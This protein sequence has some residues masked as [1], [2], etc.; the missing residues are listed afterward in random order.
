L[1]SGANYI[2]STEYG[3]LNKSPSVAGPQLQTPAYTTLDSALSLPT[4]GVTRFLVGNQVLVRSSTATRKVSYVGNSVQYD[5]IADDGQTIVESVQ[6][7]N[8]SSVQLTGVMEN[9]PEEFQAIYPINNWIT[10]NN[11]SATAK[12]QSGAAYIKRQSALV[13][14]VY[15]A[16]DCTNSYP[17]TSTRTAATTP[18]QT[19]A[20]LDNFFPISLVDPHTYESDFATDGT[21]SIINGVR[22]WVANQPM[23]P[24]DDTKAYRIY[25]E[26]NGNVYMGL[27]EKAG[28]PFLNAQTDGSVVNYSLAMNQAAVN[29]IQ[30]GVITGA[31]YGSQRGGTAE[32]PT[33]DLF[34]IG[35]HAVNGALTPVDLQAHYAIPATLTGAGQTIAIVDGPGSGSV[36]DDLNTFS[37]YYNLPL[38]DSSNPCF[39]RIDLSNGASFSAADDWGSELELDTQMVH[40]IAPGAKIILVTAN[41]GSLSDIFAAINYAAALPG[42]TA[43]TM[44]FS[45]GSY[46]PTDFLNE[47]VAL[48]GFQT[49][50]GVA[51]FASSGDNGNT[52]SFMDYPAASPYVTA[53]GGTRINSVAWSAGAQSEVAWPFSGGGESSYASMPAWQLSYLG[54]AVQAANGGMRAMPDVAAV[55][56][57]QHSAVAIYYKQRWVMSGGTSVSSP[58]WA[59][60]SALMGQKLANEGK[61]LASLIKTTPGGFNGLIYQSKV[62]QGPNVGFYDILSGSDN[63]YASPCPLCVAG[64]GYDEVT[65][66][67]APNVG[68]LLSNF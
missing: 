67:G 47:D 39:Q 11:F 1:V 22:M 24:V 4:L 55:A 54:S 53:V 6:Y 63:L 42:V 28:T 37:K 33:V 58:I 16:Q 14:D 19:E 10:A 31:A 29:S 27:L 61:S 32:V 34:G 18:C 46:F 41:S 50:Q 66:W 15:F 26:L 45:Y 8:F 64:P 2:Y 23:P 62:T 65:G 52:T 17:A 7:S 21:I 20:T 51:F 38:C 40:A 5:A 13:G 36:D 9:S 3:G 57:G 68:K 59:G 43:V 56:D 30:Q 49:N 12:W 44:S 48:S 60:I 25:Y 35:G